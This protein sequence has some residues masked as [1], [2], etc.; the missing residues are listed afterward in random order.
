MRPCLKDA[1]EKGV[2]L[3]VFLREEVLKKMMYSLSCELKRLGFTASEAKDI[4]QEWNDRCKPS[5]PVGEIKNRLFSF[6]DWVYK[7][8]AKAGCNS[9]KDYCIRQSKG[10]CFFHKATTEKREDESRNVVPFN[11]QEVDSY[12]DK[13]YPCDSVYLKGIIYALKVQKAQKKTGNIIHF[14]LRGIA[15]ALRDQCNIRSANSMDVTRKIRIL[16]EEG[17]LDIVLKGR[18]GTVGTRVANG[19]SFLP[20]KPPTV[21]LQNVADTTT[22]NFL[23]CATDTEPSHM[24]NKPEEGVK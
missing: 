5:I 1:L 9:L 14:G 18:S 23:I 24:S 11:Q 17:I 20:W 15:S 13:K 16:K 6:V 2:G 7:K 3:D 10:H 22:H 12:L 19:Y 21:R 4:L 8:E